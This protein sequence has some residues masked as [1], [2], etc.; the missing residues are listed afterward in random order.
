VQ[1]RTFAG[2]APP[3]VPYCFSPDRTAEHPAAHLASFTGL[4]QAD[5]YAR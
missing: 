4:L 3:A 5:A 2:K 1:D